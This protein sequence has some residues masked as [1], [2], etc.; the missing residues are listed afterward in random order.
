MGFGYSNVITE[1]TYFLYRAIGCNNLQT[2][3]AATFFRPV[4]AL[5]PDCQT[6]AMASRKASVALPPRCALA[7]A[8]ERDHNGWRRYGCEWQCAKLARTC[9]VIWRSSQTPKP[10]F[11]YRGPPCAHPPIGSSAGAVAPELAPGVLA[12]RR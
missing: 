9:D 10:L 6:A 11:G 1:G 12:P 7:A 8:G 3:T 2:R 4:P 5:F